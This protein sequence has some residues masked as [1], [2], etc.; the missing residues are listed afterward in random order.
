MG[1]TPNTGDIV[2][3]DFDPTKGHEQRGHR[4]A[5]VL[6]PTAYNK[7]AGLA[8]VCPITSHVKGYPFEVS[9]KYQG[10]PGAVLADQAKSL[11]WKARKVTYA[12]SA[13]PS[14]AQ[15]VKQ[16]LITLLMG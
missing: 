9:I 14:V 11:D 15:K 1:Y 12:G 13:F 3:V 6:T 8:I 16:V 2:W 7:K 10:K 4:P 5:L